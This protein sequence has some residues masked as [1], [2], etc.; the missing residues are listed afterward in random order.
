MNFNACVSQL[1]RIVNRER[2]LSAWVYFRESEGKKEDGCI[3]RDVYQQGM[4]EAF[5]QDL[6]WPREVAHRIFDLIFDRFNYRKGGA[7]SIDIY[8]L[9]VSMT[10]CSRLSYDDKLQRKSKL[11]LVVLNIIDVDE[12]RCLSIAEVFKMIFIIE[13]NF[14]LE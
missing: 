2:I 11:T 4:M 9:L 8:D 12:D 1:L 6:T 14:V 3:K 10:I 13:K 5:N 7:S